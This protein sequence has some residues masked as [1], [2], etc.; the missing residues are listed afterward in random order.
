MNVQDF[1]TREVITVSAAEP[2]KNVAKLL[3]DRRISGLP[4]VD[5]EGRLVGV[6]SEGDLLV[7]EEGERPR[8]KHR[9]RRMKE[10]EKRGARTAGEAMTSPALTVSPT[11]SVAEAAALMLEREV[12]RLPVVEGGA[13]VGIVTRADLVRAFARR[14]ADIQQELEEDV[15]L[16][17]FSIV[18]ENVNVAVLNGEVTL[19][20]EVETDGVRDT[21]LAYLEQV[22]GLVAVH[23][24]LT[25]RTDSHL[26]RAE[27]TRP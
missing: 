13:L 22:P 19:T 4:V 25:V 1:M 17:T 6:V 11:A 16:R 21:L 3:I 9:F 20:G 18:P 12:N 23:S 7:K 2:L 5:E 27:R 26:P 10:A 14:D 8:W 24:Q 15:L